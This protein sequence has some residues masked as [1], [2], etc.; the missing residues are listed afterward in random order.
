MRLAFKLE[1]SF[2]RGALSPELPLSQISPVSPVNPINPI[3]QNLT[4]NIAG[5]GEIFHRVEGS[6]KG[7]AQWKIKQSKS[8]TTLHYK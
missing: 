8:L 2:E 3:N 4:K 1:K 6:S 5:L 7:G